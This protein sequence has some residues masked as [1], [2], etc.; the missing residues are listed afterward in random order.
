GGFA[1]PSASLAD[2]DADTTAPGRRRAFGR[3]DRS[4]P[5]ARSPGAT[6]AF[7]ADTPS[8]SPRRPG[9]PGADTSATTAPRPAW[10]EGVPRRAS[11]PGVPTRG[12]PGAGSSRAGSSR[13]GS[14]ADGSSG[15][16][17]LGAGPQAA[18]VQ[19]ANR[20]AAKAASA[21]AQAPASAQ[22]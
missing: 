8:T 5:A 1:T 15:A 12:L 11:S 16:R 2:V 9:W 17:S 6:R 3:Q 18:N 22:A 13:A 20:A 21:P 10:P 14:S 7:T 19:E 4:L